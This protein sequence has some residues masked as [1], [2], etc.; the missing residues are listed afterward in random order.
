MIRTIDDVISD[1]EEEGAIPGDLST[2][3]AATLEDKLGMCLFGF[4]YGEWLN[5][6]SHEETI[7]K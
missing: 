3:Q 4:V 2:V 6:Y 1:P 7:I 5:I